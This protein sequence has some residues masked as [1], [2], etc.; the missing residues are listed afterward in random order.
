M[1]LVRT[2]VIPAEKRL[3]LKASLSSA[4]ER[5][6]EIVFAYVYGSF[7]E[8]RPFRDVDVGV[9]LARVEEERFGAY[10]IDLGLELEGILGFPID[11]RVLNTAPLSF[12]YNVFRGELLVSRDDD[13]RAEKVEDAVRHHLDTEPLVRR[14]LRELAEG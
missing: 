3:A 5:R 9:C 11:V 10:A 6:P 12:L 2:Q 1:H 13:L 14:S 4:L 7:A 8:G